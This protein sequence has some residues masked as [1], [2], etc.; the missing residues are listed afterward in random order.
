MA[1]HLALEEQ[2]QLDQLKHF[3]NVWGTLLSAV[4]LLFAIFAATWSGYKYWQNRQAVQATGLF[5]VLEA[6]VLSGD[7]PR[8]EQAFD[9]LKSK[10]TNTNQSSLAALTS[11]K[12]LYDTGKNSDSKDAL[13]WVLKNSSDDGIKS[14]ARLRLSN[15]LTTEKNYDEALKIISNDF[16]EEFLPLVADRKGDIFLLQGRTAEAILEYEKAFIK[17][18]VDSEYKRLLE[19]KLNS[20]GVVPKL[21]LKSTISAPVEKG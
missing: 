3:W 10:H 15:I 11:A 19:I 8:L 18:S 14:L 12:F 7:Q 21:T 16:S 20:L 2:E 13:T 5:D 6:A 1:N 17:F 4:V 9:D